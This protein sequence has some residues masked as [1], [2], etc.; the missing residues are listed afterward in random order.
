M[1]ILKVLGAGVV[2]LLFAASPQPQDV[3]FAQAMQ[4]TAPQAP[5]TVRVRGTIASIDGSTLTVKARDGAEMKVKLA[6]NAPVNE[7]VKALLSDIKD[8]SYLAITA[9]P[10]PDGSQKAMAI[11]I[12]PPNV[13]PAEGFSNWDLPNSTMT[14]A[15]VANQV[16][17]VDGQTLTVTYKDGEKKIMV[18]PSAEI[19]TYKKAT[20]ADL[21]PG[22]KI[23]IFA[24]KKLP[25]GGLEA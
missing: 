9:A 10:Q 13:H 8:G 17:G 16:A 15:T 23:F 2:A 21:K 14:N 1:T 11:L 18:L 24:A 12:F 6:D 25:D 3:T 22:Q 4:Q 7:V 19:I 20:M 5:Q